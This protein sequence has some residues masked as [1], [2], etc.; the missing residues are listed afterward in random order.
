MN[1]SSDQQLESFV[2]VYDAVP[3]KWEDARPFI[4][5]Q[6]KRLANAVNIREIGWFLD[7]ELLSGKAFIPGVQSMADLSTSQVF[8][9]ILRKVIVFP[10]GVVAGA[11]TIAHNIVVDANYEQIALWAC[12]TNSSAPFTSTVFGNS[13]TIRVIGPNV[14]VTSDGTYDRCKCYLEYVQEQ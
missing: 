3:D 2:P 8:R 11:N 10:T 12:A 4:V 1:D 6:F 7:E 5:E 9:S 14:I 13:D